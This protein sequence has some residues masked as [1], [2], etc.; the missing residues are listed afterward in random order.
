MSGAAVHTTPTRRV[1]RPTGVTSA[2]GSVY[3]ATG[4]P[5]GL[6][7]DAHGVITGRTTEIG[8]TTVTVSI[9]GNS[10]GLTSFTF[11]WIVL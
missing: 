4:L 5:T 6:S 7:M 8:T 2:T 9:T 3:A 10:E 11:D 1:P